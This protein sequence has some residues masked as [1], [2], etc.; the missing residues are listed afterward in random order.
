MYD[1]HQGIEEPDEAKVSC[2]VLESSGVGDYFTDFN[3]L[4]A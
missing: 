3:N 4:L 1:K 2:P